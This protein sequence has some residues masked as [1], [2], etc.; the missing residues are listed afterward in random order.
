MDLDYEKIKEYHALH[1]YIEEHYQAWKTNYLF[2]DEIHVFPFSF[3]E[4]CEYYKEIS[5]KD[6]LF[7]DYSMNSGLAGSYAY[8]T[9]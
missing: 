4:Y 1:T 9:E 5:D 3:G 2:V 7:D 6:Q 8:R